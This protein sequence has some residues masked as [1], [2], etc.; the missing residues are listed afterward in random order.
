[1]RD[2]DG[3]ELR[4]DKLVSVTGLKLRITNRSTSSKG[5][6]SDRGG[7]DGLPFMMLGA[8]QF[9][10]LESDGVTVFDFRSTRGL[11][12][13][14]VVRSSDTNINSCWYPGHC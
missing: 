12:C 1:M 14:F 7:R 11:A 2:G 4:G 10:L 13:F 3:S 8:S 5:Q 6:D 9:L